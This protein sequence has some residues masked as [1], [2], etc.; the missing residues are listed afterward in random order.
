MENLIGQVFQNWPSL[1]GL[2]MLAW[3]LYRQ[4]ERL[5]TA[6]LDDIKALTE[7]VEALE[8]DISQLRNK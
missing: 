6:V 8:V 3:V 4:N 2:I 7:R 5:M 1:A